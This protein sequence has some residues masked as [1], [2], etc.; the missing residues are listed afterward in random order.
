M[1]DK[2]PSPPPPMVAGIL[3]KELAASIDPPV[4]GKPAVHAA[5]GPEPLVGPPAPPAVGKV[6][7]LDDERGSRN[8]LD[9][10]GGRAS[11]G[12]SEPFDTNDDSP[13]AMPFDSVVRLP[14]AGARA[15][16]AGS[17]GSEGFDPPIEFI[18][19]PG[20]A[21]GA[22]GRGE[23]RSR[24]MAFE[25]KR[26]AAGQILN[27]RYLV[28][29][30]IG[31][32]AMGEVYRAEDRRLGGNVALKFLT[33]HAAADADSLRR[34]L[35]EASLA[36]I[37]TH[38]NVCR[39]FDVGDVDGSA[40]IS[41]EFVDGE[42]ISSL[43]RRIGRLPADKALS[44][45]HQL[46]AGLAGAHEKKVLHRDLKP[47]NIMLDGNGE[48]RIADF[49][50]S[51]H[52]EDYGKDRG[53]AGTPAYMAPEVLR[54]QRATVQSDLFSLGLILY[55]VF[56]GKPVYRPTTISQLEALHDLPL[57]SPVTIVPD[58]HPDVARAIMA[59]LERAP[60]LRPNS[61]RELA[62]MLPGGDALAAAI[63]A[64]QVPSVRQI[65]A[66][67][68]EGIL[69]PA[70]LVLLSLAMAVSLAGAI[71]IGQFVSLI[72]MVPMRKSAQVLAANAEEAVERLGYSS[73]TAYKAS[74]FD[75]YDEYVA[76]IKAKDDSS[77]RWDRLSLPRPSPIDFW[78]R[79]SPR[80]LVTDGQ[81]QR[82]SLYDPPFT[83]GG[84]INIRLDTRGRLREFLYF[85]P[86]EGPVQVLDGPS[87]KL[88]VVARVGA[89]DASGEKQEMEGAGTPQA[90]AMLLNE[91]EG[92]RLGVAE[93]GV[94]GASV[95]EPA[96]VKQEKRGP[97]TRP[98]DW[99]PVF[100]LA[101][102]SLEGFTPAEH[103]RVPPVFG[104][105]RMTWEGVYPDV[106]SEA[107]RIEAASLNGRPVAFRIVEKDWVAASV[108]QPDSA[109]SWLKAGRGGTLLAEAIA[110]IAI[111]LLAVKNLRERIGDRRASLR[112][113]V[114]MGVATA[115]M[116]L[117]KADHIGHLHGEIDF[118]IRAITLSV[119]TVVWFWLAY[120]A[121]EPYARRVW[122]ETL[123]SWSRISGG[124]VLSP[125]VG[126][127][128]AWGCVGGTV[129][130][131]LAYLHRLSPAWIGYPPAFPW[132]DPE[133]GLEPLQGASNAVGTFA[134]LLP[135]SAKYALTFLVMLL[136]LRMVLKRKWL[137]A[138]AYVAI[139]S[140]LWLLLRGDSPLSLI[141][142]TAVASI[143]ALLL[144]R[145]GILGLMVGVVV[146]H[147][148]VIF[149]P[150]VKFGSFWMATASTAL[151]GVVFVFS[152]ALLAAY[153]VFRRGHAP[154]LGMARGSSSAV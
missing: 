77:H 48:V 51:A 91:R 118:L 148:I 116:V 128:V 98:V 103:I 94:V 125:L 47:A 121:I 97:Q 74:G 18:P 151:A 127:H 154:A 99:Q 123:I 84:M 42:T 113:A 67:G 15:S 9:E 66:A 109:T 72:R 107:V 110:A 17:Q 152:L 140:I 32:G 85:T 73:E 36:R 143:C 30:Q 87:Q 100:A 13:L 65:A 26:F 149:A 35:A 70:Q 23:G 106:P 4:R 146:F 144:I 12:V 34:L 53:R 59:C 43:L 93:L 153:G 1:I 57:P 90:G 33:A 119:P 22:H 86:A 104:D 68:G 44:V 147:V 11:G 62:G 81:Y 31:E 132:F 95:G 19:R 145:V 89:G 2:A 131:S 79:Q 56:T 7:T 141:F 126:N 142:T 3:P 138:A 114:F 25:R 20:G 78:Y 120:I 76:M 105:E 10:R 135:F 117:L 83:T 71:I 46:C 124:D 122:P 139:Q 28:I 39:I 96:E 137:A 5:N 27:R 60:S 41:M 102:L 88:Q 58:L 63:D 38:P 52:M 50:L 6:T 8:E 133:Q 115:L 69:R 92:T 16:E 37:V 129:C 64:G 82:V 45:A 24:A 150:A 111:V 112:L 40:F 101:G 61:A 108:S 130:A 29:A 54:G 136:L 80:P 49:G 134:G 14:S 75:F 21:A 55:E